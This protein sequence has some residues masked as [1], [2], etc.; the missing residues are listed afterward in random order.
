[1]NKNAYKYIA[2]NEKS[3]KELA[4]KVAGTKA[5]ASLYPNLLTIVI[6]TNEECESA[7]DDAGVFIDYKGLD[8]HIEPV[9]VDEANIGDVIDCPTTDS[10]TLRGIVKQLLQEKSKM[11]A[12]HKDV[13]AQLRKQT[14]VAIKEKESYQALSRAYYKRIQRIDVQLKA[15]SVLIGSIC[16]DK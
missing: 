12:A 11:E 9:E 7:I 8:F 10:G 16:Q 6:T 5:T 14:E 1:M 13:T 2:N 3:Y 4:A 15:L